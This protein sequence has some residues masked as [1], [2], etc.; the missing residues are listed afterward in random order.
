MSADSRLALSVG[1]L[2]GLCERERRRPTDQTIDGQ[3][4]D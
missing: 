1:A 3:T 4:F 2:V